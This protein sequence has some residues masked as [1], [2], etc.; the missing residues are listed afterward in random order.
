LDWDKKVEKMNSAIASS[1]F[2]CKKNS[3][4]E[5]LIGLGLLIEAAEFSQKWVDLFRGKK[6]RR[7]HLWWEFFGAVDEF[8]LIRATKIS[9]SAWISIYKTM[10]AWRLL[11]LLESQSH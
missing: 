5:F 3:Y 10:R 6:R 2:K 1:K 9:P 7:T 4:E 8:N 11:L